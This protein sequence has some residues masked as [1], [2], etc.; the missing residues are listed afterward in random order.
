MASGMDLQSQLMML[1]LTLIVLGILSWKASEIGRLQIPQMEYGPIIS[2]SVLVWGS[3][4]R[5][6]FCESGLS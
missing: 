6:C 4:G 3:D 1:N 5:C 2:C